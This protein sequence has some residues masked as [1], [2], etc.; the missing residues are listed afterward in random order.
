MQCAVILGV[1]T[2][3]L[4][5]LVIRSD[6]CWLPSLTWG[7]SYLVISLQGQFPISIKAVMGFYDGWLASEVISH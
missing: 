6:Y 3:S 2:G 4:G 7:Q 1:I 5:G